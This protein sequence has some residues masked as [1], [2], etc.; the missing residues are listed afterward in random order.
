MEVRVEEG[1]AGRGCRF[2]YRMKARVEG[3]ELMEGI[4][5]R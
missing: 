2:V 5:W 4:W 3:G 1:G